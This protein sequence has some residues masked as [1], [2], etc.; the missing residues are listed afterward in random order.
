MRLTGKGKGVI[1]VNST[2]LQMKLF[3][4]IVITALLLFEGAGAVYGG[5]NLVIHPDGSSLGLSVAL[6][7]YALFP[8][9]L[10]P[11]IILLG[12]NGVFSLF[13]FT[14]ILI[15]RRNYPLLVV[16]QGAL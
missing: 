14:C 7:R 9:F 2:L 5:L 11:G 3:V 12:L 8:N 15:S 10:I 1:F 4:K 16:I 13:V 6:L